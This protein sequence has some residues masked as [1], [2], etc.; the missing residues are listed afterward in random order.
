MTR[1]LV[2]GSTVT[3]AGGA[4]AGLLAALWHP[5]AALVVLLVTAGL[6]IA[7]VAGLWP[8]RGAAA[9]AGAAPAAA[10]AAPAAAGAAPAPAPVRALRAADLVLPPAALVPQAADPV[11]SITLLPERRAPL[12][13][14]ADDYATEALVAPARE[15]QVHEAQVHELPRALPVHPRA[16]RR[17]A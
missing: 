4:G 8:S 14:G 7:L 2:A 10:G 16:A 6:A 15:A 5:T 11:P 9:A 17:G 13:G 3:I 12:P 1:V